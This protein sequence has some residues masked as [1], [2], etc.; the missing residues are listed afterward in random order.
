MSS[1]IVEAFGVG[2]AYDLGGGAVV[3]GGVVKADWN[4]NTMFDLGVTM[5]F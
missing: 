5:S 3:K 2:A 1:L 4:K